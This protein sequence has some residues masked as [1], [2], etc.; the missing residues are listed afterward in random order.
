MMR[1]FST[2]EMLI[3]M[4]ILVLGISAVTLLT[5]GTA[6]LSV[7]TE[8][9]REALNRVQEMLEKQQA[10]ARKD[11]KLVVS[12]TTSETIDNLTYQERIDV[13]PTFDYLP[14]PEYLYTR[15]VVA[16]VSW[17]GMYGRSQS[18]SLSTFVTNFENSVGG[19]TCYS[20]LSGNWAAPSVTSM[21]L[22]GISGLAD[23]SG[24][25]PISDIDVYE[26]KL[27]VSTA[28]S[29]A[30]LG[31]NNPGA[32]DG[33][34]GSGISWS[35]AGNVTASDNNRA[36]A[37]LSSGN[38]TRYLKASNFGFNIPKGSTI[39][40]IKV[41][42]ER[43]I[44][45]STSGGVKDS[46]VR[47][48]KSDGTL[49]SRNYADTGTSWPVQASESYAA[50]NPS[51]IWGESLSYANINSS[52]FGV[53]ISAAA[54]SNR[55]AQ[56]DNIRITVTYTKALY[57]L[58]VSVPASPKFL[59]GLAT[60]SLS[61]GF[62]A[63]AVATSSAGSFAYAVPSNTTVAQLQI[64]DIGPTMA[65]SPATS[66]ALLKS[67]YSF[68]SAPSGRAKSIYYANGYVY[69][70]LVAAG[71]APEF[72][73]IDVHNP[74]APV[75]LGSWPSGESPV[76]SSDINSISVA[77]TYAYLAHPANSPFNE[78]VTIIDVSD[79]IH[80]KRVGGSWNKS[81]SA[82]TGNG[83]SV[84]IVGDTPYLGRASSNT[85]TSD[86]IPELYGF[87]LD[88]SNL[89]AVATT[90]LNMP[91]SIIPATDGI[92]GLIV[93]DH[94]AFLNTGNKATGN[95]QL[96]IYDIANPAN[97]SQVGSSIFFPNGGAPAGFDC[98]ANY[99]WAASVPLSGAN[100]NK[101][102]LSLITS[103]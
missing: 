30:A 31:P 72:H 45:G 53:A 13:S 25:Y 32:G 23:P 56:V 34:S 36:T 57:I 89:A 81:S 14:F 82:T 71:T 86:T 43:S 22:G 76:F 96:R 4:T 102:A 84:Y 46:E 37:S 90:S 73:I 28:A 29:A 38:S 101:G 91:L 39:T 6:S 60:S 35:S 41:E 92:Y 16:T 99:L 59:G 27:F 52:N 100:A 85:L 8:T 15:K 47:I 18:E 5:P 7:D 3:A 62:S 24:L 12:T 19:D 49:G 26:K 83:E 2:V 9:D 88:S 79:P 77:G 87:T 17:P 65:A 1:G 67:T 69:V 63:I 21:T 33:S 97:P 61:G 11:F 80:P 10:L 98:E 44:A 78:Q 66:P 64:I 54:T 48:V 42:V 55:T 95:G 103:L 58:D 51:D 94:Y 68:P 93:R 75:E 70:G 40:G 20:M 50:Y 74:S